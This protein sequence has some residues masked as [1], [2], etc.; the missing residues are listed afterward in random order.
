MLI[1]R[2]RLLF[3]LMAGSITAAF[4]LIIA[5]N[6]QEEILN[7]IKGQ[8]VLDMEH[9]PIEFDSDEGEI[10][11]RKIISESS[12]IGYTYF[13]A[14]SNQPT[15]LVDSK[16]KLPTGKAFI[17][18]V[19]T[20]N[21]VP[22]K[23]VRVSLYV[24]EHSITERSVTNDTGEYYISL[25][26]GKYTITGYY[27]ETHQAT[28]SFPGRLWTIDRKQAE[29]FPIITSLLAKKTVFGPNFNFSLLED[30]K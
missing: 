17:S 8:P 19:V 23:G 9:N 10:I 13:N 15:N 11:S 26:S 30:T 25:P 28:E 16:E 21:H 1:L 22:I 3:G 7:Q 12:S 2:K 20:I 18:G 14:T 5:N 27:I 6:H 24:D 4:I 29:Q